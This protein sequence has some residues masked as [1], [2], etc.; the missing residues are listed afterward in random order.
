MG[1]RRKATGDLERLVGF[2]SDGEVVKSI[3]VTLVADTDKQVDIPEGTLGIHVNHSL[4]APV[5]FSRSG[6]ITLPTDETARACGFLS[7]NVDSARVMDTDP[8]MAGNKLHLRC[9]SPGSLYL[10]FWG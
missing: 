2:S 1:T 3:L 5:F 9:A 10:E 6:V 8:I 4:A 7:P